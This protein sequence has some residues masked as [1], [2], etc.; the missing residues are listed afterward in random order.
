MRRH[1]L[2]NH[3]YCRRTL[4]T[5]RVGTTIMV[6]RQ[7]G[8]RG[9]PQSDT[10]HYWA[11]TRKTTDSDCWLWSSDRR[12]KE[13]DEVWALKQE[14][15]ILFYEKVEE[16]GILLED[17]SEN[18]AMERLKAKAV[19]VDSEDM[20]LLDSVFKTSNEKP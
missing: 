17:K 7:G 4:I 16:A 5:P 6:G 20:K 12:V 11:V 3:A 8:K 10:G 14:S 18:E 13:V 1:A 9:V 15:Y 2:H 19:G